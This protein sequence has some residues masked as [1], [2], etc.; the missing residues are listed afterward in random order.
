MNH[1][2][3]DVFFFDSVDFLLAGLIAYGAAGLASGLAAGLA[4]AAAGMLIP[5]N[6]GFSD[7]FNVFHNSFFASEFYV[8]IILYN[9]NFCNCFRRQNKKAVIFLN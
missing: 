1:L 3:S 4:F 8:D 7:N 6:G 5:A 9:T 2:L